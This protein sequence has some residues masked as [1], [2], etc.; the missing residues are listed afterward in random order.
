SCAVCAD[1]YGFFDI[2]QRIGRLN[3]EELNL[4]VMLLDYWGGI[5]RIENNRG[6]KVD[7][8]V[9]RVEIKDGE[10]E[11]ELIPLYGKILSFTFTD[12]GNVKLALKDGA[13]INGLRSTSL[14]INDTSGNLVLDMRAKNYNVSNG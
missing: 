7:E 8:I 10:M 2:F 9:G 12:R 14:G 3:I 1:K 13:Y 11:R 5:I 4:A 6:F